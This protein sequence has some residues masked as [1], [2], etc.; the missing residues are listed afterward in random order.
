MNNPLQLMRAF[1]NPQEFLKQFEQMNNPIMNNAI[2][3]MKQGKGSQLEELVRNVAKEKGVNVDDLRK[4]I[5][6]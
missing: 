3:L 2:G 5:G 1:R 6:F 4:Q